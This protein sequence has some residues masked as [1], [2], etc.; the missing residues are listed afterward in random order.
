MI[1]FFR[2]IRKKLLNQ[3]RFNKYMLYAIGEI[4]LVVIG[5]LIALQINDWNDQKKKQA[6]ELKILKEINTNLGF[7]L[8]EIRS[9]ISVMDSVDYAIKYVINH[10]KTNEIPSEE[11]K[12]QVV[13]LRTAPHF[14]PNKS[15]YE[16]L[17]SK[18]VDIIS[19]DS[20]RMAISSMYE[21]KYPY[22][23]KYESER[24]I[25]KGDIIHP[26]L[27]EN[28]EW[29]LDNTKAFYA[30]SE[31]SEEDYYKIKHNGSF[32]KLARASEHENWLV[33][34][35]AKKLEANIINLIDFIKVEIITQEN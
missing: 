32:L 22:Y 2:T 30:T 1:K 3:N 16:L 11:F 9:D 28:F 5:I 33:H 6:L 10:I 27:I 20:L 15:G 19:N 26:K 13:K 8:E 14:D 35:R 23:N 17:I 18:G 21:S 31:I 25:F 12:D 4:I 34:D 7:D 24:I 29:L